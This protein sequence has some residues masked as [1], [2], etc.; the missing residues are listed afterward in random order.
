MSS[1]FTVL[2][3]LVSSSLIERDA[4]VDAITLAL[5]ARCHVLF[6]GPPGTAKSL[7]ARLVSQA[8]DA[9]YCERLL[10]PTTPPEALFGPPDLKALTDS[11]EYKHISHGT[12]TEA[13]IVFLDEFFRGSDAIR[14][15]LLHLLGPERQALIGTQQVK[16]PLVTA[17]G[18]ANSWADGIDQAAIM[19]RWLIRRTVKPVGDIAR[20]LF[21]D[22]PPVS[23]TATLAD[24]EALQATADQMPLPNDAREC[25]MAI[26]GDLSVEGIR[27]SDRRMRQCVGVVRASAALNG[28][29][30]ARPLDM[31]CLV[32]VLW[33]QPE[34]ASKAMEIVLRHANPAGAK[35]MV[36]LAD[37]EDVVTKATTPETR[38]AALAKLE[39]AKKELQALTGLN[40][41]A[42]KAIKFI[43]THQVRI[44]AVM[45][46]ISPDKA[47]A[48]LGAF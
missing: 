47:A 42:E 29:P 20:L 1:T 48:L 23:P 18:A 44:Q 39:D 26:I 25:L 11:G 40:G 12:I 28:V 17:I 2:R 34:Q 31:E 36:L 43:R 22:L 10:S 37:V 38:M 41:R 13:E 6:V 3:K 7:V 19:D 21:D 32:D 27:C 16:V 14:D 24:L 4:E 30:E 33:D 5:V 15:T 35:L 9:R 45:L 46:G 8:V